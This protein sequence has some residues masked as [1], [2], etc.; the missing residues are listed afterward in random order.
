MC[1][2]RPRSFLGLLSIFSALLFTVISGPAANRIWT[3]AGTG[4]NWTTAANWSNNVAPVAGDFLIF[5]SGVT[6][7]LVTN[8]LVASTIFS[9]FRIDADYTLRGNLVD[10]TNIVIVN[11]LGVIVDLSA[12]LLTNVTFAI[13]NN[14]YLYWA[15]EI[16]LI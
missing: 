3:G 15:G 12:R 13:S 7:T 9:G 16:Q 8:N 11:S 14:S 2:A 1:A 6:K 5:P 4:A 10:L